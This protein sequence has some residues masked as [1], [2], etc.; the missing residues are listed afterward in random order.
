MGKIKRGGSGLEES[1]R[2]EFEYSDGVLSTQMGYSISP[3]GNKQ[4][5]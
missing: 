3:N 5:N 2:L 1:A 4:T